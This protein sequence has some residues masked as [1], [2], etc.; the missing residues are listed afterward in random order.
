MK[1]YTRHFRWILEKSRI[2]FAD[3]FVSA[4]WCNWSFFFRFRRFA[5]TMVALPLFLG[6]SV[7]DGGK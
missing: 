6:E 1:N 7:P 3:F 5:A 2:E 4:L